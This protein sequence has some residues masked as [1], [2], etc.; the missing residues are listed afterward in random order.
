M[1]A[2]STGNP[3]ANPFALSSDDGYFWLRGNLHCHSTNSDGK[4]SPQQRLDGYV[5][6]DYGFLCLSDHYTIT[7]VETVQAPDD[8]VLV[9]GAELHPANPFGG[10]TH[11]F[12]CL[13]IREDM[14]SQ[15]LP[16]QM[17]IDNVNEQGGSVWLAHPHWSS[18]K[19]PRDTLPLHGLAG[20]E[21]F[22]TICR[23]HGRGEGSVMWD[24]WM[25]LE[26]QLYPMLAND[27]AHGSDADDAYQS[28]TMARV[29]ERTVE[30]VCE[31][32]ANGCTYGSTGPQIH[33]IKLCQVGTGEQRQVEATVRCS[34][35]RRVAAVCDRVGTEYW[36]GGDTFEE[37]TF[38]IRANSRWARFEVIGPDG[39]KA[40]SNP[41]DLTAV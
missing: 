5:E 8:F 7:R 37:C 21:V 13:N 17:V 9:P 10:Q 19:I 18:V 29:K 3:L 35:A 33:D 23:R 4:V 27:D 40:W 38:A 14:D 25:E 1:T 36:E 31:A 28:W 2:T 16:P 6:R 11:H 39:Y 30:A 32:L 34:E 15:R 20:I 22:N 24:D 26:D 41:F 12:V